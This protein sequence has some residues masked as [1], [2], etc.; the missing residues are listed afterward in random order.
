MIEPIMFIGIGFLVAGLLVIGVIPLVHA[1]AVRLTMQRIEALTPSSMAEIQA[2]K[3][4]LRAELAMSMRRLEMRV[5]QMKA[6]T[7]SQ[8]AEIGKKS[9]SIGRLKLE[10]G[11]KTAPLFLLEARDKQLTEDLSATHAEIAAKIEALQATERKLADTQAELG[12]FTTNFDEAL[13]TVDSQRAELVALR[14]QTEVLKGQ[15]DSYE[16][17]ARNLTERLTQETSDVLMLNQQL[18][19]ER[20]RNEILGNRISELEP[21]LVAQMTEAES[22]GRRV[23][24]LVAQL[25]EQGRFLAEREYD[26]GQLRGLAS[27]AQTTESD[28]RAEFAEAENRRSVMTETLRSEKALVEEQLRQSEDERANLQREIASIK[29]EAESAWATERM[30]NAVL[31]E[32]T[33]DATAEVARLTSVLEGRG[34]PIETILVSDA[35]RGHANGSNGNGY[36]T[37]GANGESSK[38]TLADRILALQS[39][40]VR[41][42]QAS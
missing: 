9:E 27:A 14:P 8:L 36:G 4:Q 37:I 6:K 26:A 11:E 21:R 28:V 3:D 18:S 31:R 29:R 25:D 38:G 30:E 16:K 15:I 34:S 19:E 23:Q 7:T 5:D 33:N 12:K 41:V 2:D 32:R 1:R 40:T 13:V 17:E 42:P 22:L 20:G 24:E 10:L 35:G 39:R